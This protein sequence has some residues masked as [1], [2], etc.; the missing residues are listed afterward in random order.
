[1]LPRFGYPQF[2]GR[3]PLPQASSSSASR[4]GYPQF[5]G[6]PP[7][8]AAA[9]TSPRGL[10]TLNSGGV[11]PTTDRARWTCAVW[12]PS[13]LGASTPHRSRYRV[14]AG[15]GYPQFWGRPPQDGKNVW[16]SLWVWLP[17]ILGASTPDGGT[18][19][20]GDRFGYPQFWGRPPLV[21]F[22]ELRYDGFGYP[23]FWGRPPPNQSRSCFP[24]RFG[25]PQFWGRP[26]PNWWRPSSTTGLAT[27]NSG[28]VHPTL[29]VPLIL[30]AVWLPSILG[31]S[32]PLAGGLLVA[33]GFGYPQFWGR[34]PLLARYCYS[35]R[36]L[37][38]L[39]S[40]GVHPRKPNVD[41]PGQGLAT[42]NSGGVHPRTL[43]LRSNMLGLATLNSGG[44]HPCRKWGERRR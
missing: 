10:A 35:M 23:Q 11:H 25:Y 1:M 18:D 28:G 13:I 14:H 19:F 9:S 7:R 36:G 27:L 6:R 5:W 42:L 44:V 4:F 24:P 31:A 37:A 22:P 40:G 39:N 21:L 16:L 30:T 32:T 41:A 26:P 33:A 43:R 3:P 2:W 38:T 12:L 15:F 8:A 29:P 20:D 34:P 17:S